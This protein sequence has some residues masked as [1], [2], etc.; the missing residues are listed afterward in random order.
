MSAA[1]M[2][3]HASVKGDEETLHYL[4]AQ[5]AMSAAQAAMSAAQA[6]KKSKTRRLALYKVKRQSEFDVRRGRRAACVRQAP[7]GVVDVASP[8]P[9]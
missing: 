5:E 6:T 7:D 8:I 2:E 9:D 3:A 4:R 1:E